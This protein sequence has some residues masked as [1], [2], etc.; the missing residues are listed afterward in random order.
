MR[1]FACLLVLASACG[2]E[3]GAVV[4]FAGDM[5]EADRVEVVLASAKSDHVT[6]L[7]A[8][9]TD[10]FR[11]RINIDAVESVG[12]L[13]ALTFRIQPDAI[14]APEDTFIPFVFAFAGDALVGVAVFADEVGEPGAITIES[15]KVM[16][17]TLTVTAL[18]QVGPHDV[19]EPATGAIVE[20]GGWRSGYVWQPRGG[21]KQLRVMLPDPQLDA[22]MK[23]ATMRTADLDCDG[24]N[25]T[26]DDCDD[27][28]S[29]VYPGA[30]ERCDGVD[31]DCDGE[32]IELV[33]CTGANICADESVQL[34]KDDGVTPPRACLPAASC[35]CD[36]ANGA[37]CASCAF[38]YHLN[39][40]TTGDKA[41]CAPAAGKRHFA[42][43][44]QGTA[45][46]CRV[47]VVSVTGPFEVK[48]AP[49][50]SGP[51]ESSVMLPA[52]IDYAFLRAELTETVTFTEEQSQSVGEVYFAISTGGVPELVA[53]DL[54]IGESAGADAPCPPTAAG[55]AGDAALSCY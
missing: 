44:Q 9:V 1:V 47:Q 8:P 11:Q 6:A 5:V 18:R 2:S 54:E 27:L 26:E 48:V 42:Q 30:E 4:G 22:A 39:D 16:Q 21:G 37:S 17:Y 53:V 43:C 35:A 45:T 31:A 46:G 10:Y 38:A 28:R 25:V 52:G 7:D 50:P 13:D 36:P 29:D 19:I 15:G 34:C 24:R 32:D 40:V 33:A 23:S 14:E 41:L 3:G 49:E 12:S 55:P 51:Y 20:C